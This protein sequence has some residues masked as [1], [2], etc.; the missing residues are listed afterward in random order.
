MNRTTA[1][2]SAS[3]RA[4]YNLF[5]NY[6]IKYLNFIRRLFNSQQQITDTTRAIEVGVATVILKFIISTVS[7]PYITRRVLDKYGTLTAT[8]QTRNLRRRGR[9]QSKSE[10]FSNEAHPTD[11]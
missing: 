5:R 1:N 10:H 7:L 6:P 2:G 4:I 9:R 3:R 8:V 11:T